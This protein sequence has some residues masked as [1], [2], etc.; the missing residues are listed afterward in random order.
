M[1]PVRRSRFVLAVVAP[2]ALGAI[3]ALGACAAAGPVPTDTFYR[4]TVEPPAVPVV[5]GPPRVEALEVRPLD[6]DGIL[7]E[8][9]L[10]F[11]DGS[12]GGSLRQ[13][14][15]HFWAEA[16][17]QAVQRELAEYLRR[18]GIA[19]QVVTPRFRVRPDVDVQGRIG[20]LEQVLESGGAAQA[21]VEVE[22][23][24]ERVGRDGGLVLLRT[25][26]AEVPVASPDAAAATE[27][28]R[29]ALSDIFARFTADLAQAL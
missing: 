20:R 21:V 15:Y 12:D 28:M 1:T 10:V 27:A 23:G 4:L 19:G 29:R 8:R 18:S 2:L 13:Y 22:L 17:T 24:A 7:A 25:Y 26:R 14:S 16:P 5:S 9:A 11:S 3:L 6:A